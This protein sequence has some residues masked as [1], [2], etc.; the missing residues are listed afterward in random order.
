MAAVTARNSSRISGRMLKTAA[1]IRCARDPDSFIFY[2]A[3]AR[4]NQ[5]AVSAHSHCSVVIAQLV[6]GSRKLRSEE[7]TSEL[8]SRGHLVCRLLLEKKKQEQRTRAQQPATTKP[9][10]LD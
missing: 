4:H 7:H 2:S 8:Q 10:C 3:C 9:A 5:T 6:L 1:A